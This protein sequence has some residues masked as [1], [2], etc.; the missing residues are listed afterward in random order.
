MLEACKS[1]KQNILLCLTITKIIF[2]RSRSWLL[3]YTTPTFRG[4]YHET[5]LIQTLLVWWF[6]KQGQQME[7]TAFWHQVFLPFHKK[8]SHTYTYVIQIWDCSMGSHWEMWVKLWNCAC[9]IGVKGP[10]EGAICS[11]SADTLIL[12]V[13]GG[14]AQQWLICSLDRGWWDFRYHLGP[15]PWWDAAHALTRSSW[16][17]G[18]GGLKSLRYSPGLTI[19]SI[20]EQT[21]NLP[22]VSLS[23]RKP[24]KVMAWLTSSRLPR[25]CEFSLHITLTTLLSRHSVRRVTSN[26]DSY[27][28]VHYKRV[29]TARHEEQKQQCWKRISWSCATMPWLSMLLLSNCTVAACSP[30]FNTRTNKRGRKPSRI[31]K[32]PTL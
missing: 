5:L 12:D 31:S 22:L 14:T 32:G 11:G 26:Y 19:W 16:A 1:I 13:R 30:D 20:F 28:I 8:L 6:T 15:Q 23:F 2:Y 29:P 21:E 24:L 7:L 27:L 18:C 25:G 9:S 4:H 17:K 10:E 3:L